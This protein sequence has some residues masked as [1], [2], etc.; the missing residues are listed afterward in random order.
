MLNSRRPD[1]TMTTT[2]E[3][4][5]RPLKHTDLPL[6]HWWRSTPHVSRWY[7]D[8]EPGVA[9]TYEEVVAGYTPCIEGSE[10][11]NPF[12]VLH[13]DKPIGYIQTYRIADHPDYSRY[14]DE[15]ED[16]AGVDLFIG[17]A[18]YIHRGLGPVILR[19]FLRGI[20]FADAGVVS[21]IIGPEPENRAAIRAY[22]KAGLRYL[23]TIHVSDEPQPEYLMRIG[24]E[25][26][27]G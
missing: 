24:R 26:V 7:Y 15:S 2:D 13:R 18:E 8:S 10:P 9:P 6:M 3:I 20:V 21:C 19:R 1:H 12:L 23:K 5:F 27:A 11:T 17:E 16:A 25:D 22:E 4:G 14:V